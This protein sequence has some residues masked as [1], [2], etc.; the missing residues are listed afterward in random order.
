MGIEPAGF[1]LIGSVSV[2][3]ALPSVFSL[4][5]WSV[6]FFDTVFL[7]GFGTPSGL[8]SLPCD[9]SQIKPGLLSVGLVLDF[10]LGILICNLIPPT[11]LG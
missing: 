3:P 9:G 4:Q 2:L 11:P 5:L 7:L 10:G 8:G 1:L 6:V